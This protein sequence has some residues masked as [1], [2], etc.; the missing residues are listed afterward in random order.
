MENV[1]HVNQDLDLFCWR[2]YLIICHFYLQ[3]QLVVCEIS[4]I[5]SNCSRGKYFTIYLGLFSNFFVYFPFFTLI[6]LSGCCVLVGWA[7][8]FCLIILLGKS[9]IDKY[10]YQVILIYTFSNFIEIIE[11]GGFFTDYRL[12]I[13]N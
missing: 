7:G 10:K 6:F 12:D 8:T 4:L 3:L 11:F 13:T 2:L 5:T 1:T 9:G